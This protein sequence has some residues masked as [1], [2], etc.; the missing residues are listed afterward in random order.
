MNEQDARKAFAD[1]EEVKALLHSEA[2]EKTLVRLEDQLKDL[3][4][5]TTRDQVD[6]RDHA[7]TAI[8]VARKFRQLMIRIAEDG[9]LA[10]AD[11]GLEPSRNFF[12]WR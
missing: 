5:D 8:H 6:L 12:K 1:G 3:M 7:H 2:F 4:A 9:D 11:L 10:A